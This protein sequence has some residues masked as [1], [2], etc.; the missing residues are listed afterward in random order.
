M[1]RKFRNT[2]Q[3]IKSRFKK[4]N[5]AGAFLSSEIRD[6]EGSTFM[7]VLVAVVILSIITGGAVVSMSRVFQGSD[8]AMKKVSY[9]EKIMLLD[10]TLKKSLQKVET[11][12]FLSTHKT[13]EMPG[14]LIIYYYEGKSDSS[15]ILKGGE[16][17]VQI[18]QGETIVFSSELITGEFSLMGQYVVFTT[19]DE[20]FTFKI[21][22]GSFV[23]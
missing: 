22:L 6:E 19:S 11:P 12:W 7:E 1:N 21:R 23:L 20:K 15:V 18:L 14:E 4:L 16:T 9:Y 3:R 2:L 10:G 5:A 8:K 17:G 13:E